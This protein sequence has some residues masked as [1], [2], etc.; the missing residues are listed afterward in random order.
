MAE[1]SLDLGSHGRH[2]ENKIG[3]S[4]ENESLEKTTL[5]SFRHI[6]LTFNVVYTS[7]SITYFGS[8]SINHDN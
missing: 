8:V 3:N 4:V 2:T 6:R 5:P 7:W 1:T